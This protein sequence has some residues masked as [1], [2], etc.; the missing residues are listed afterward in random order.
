[1]WLAVLLAALCMCC[2]SP[3]GAV[4]V[5]AAG[6]PGRASFASSSSCP[7][8]H[9]WQRG[10]EVT[11]FVLDTVPPPISQEAC[12]SLCSANPNC[13]A[14]THYPLGR[15]CVLRSNGS[16]TARCVGGACATAVLRD[17]ASQQGGHFGRWSL[18]TNGA[19]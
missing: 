13:A 17:I 12:C 1:M 2:C 3:W 5:E 15:G 10:V 7:A 11:G 6:P 19:P 9:L 4:K 8:A 16:A 18:D 14:V